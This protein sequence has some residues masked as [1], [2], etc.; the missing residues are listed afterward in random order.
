MADRSVTEGKT[1]AEIMIDEA[2]KRKN[3][4]KSTSKPQTQSDTG[5]Q[6]AADKL[7]AAK[8]KAGY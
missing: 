4:P 6:S 1:P 8:A 5:G 2:K 3:K 7:K